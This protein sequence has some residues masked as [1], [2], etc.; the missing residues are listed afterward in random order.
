MTLF[1]LCSLPKQILML[2]KISTTVSS[3]SFVHATFNP[4]CKFLRGAWNEVKAQNVQKNLCDVWTADFCLRP[5]FPASERLYSGAVWQSLS[6]LL[7]ECLFSEQ[8]AYM[9]QATRWSA[10]PAPSLGVDIVFC[11]E[12]SIT[13][14]LLTSPFIDKTCQHLSN[15]V[16]FSVIKGRNTSWLLF[17]LHYHNFELV[18]FKELCFVW[19]VASHQRQ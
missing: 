1:H 3:A 7:S 12:T 8:T 10:L 9:T 13:G 5:Y 18:M 19:D 4:K 15:Y 14:K 11:T 17:C 6:F 16:C 2:D